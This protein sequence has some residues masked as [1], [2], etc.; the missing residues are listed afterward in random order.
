MQLYLVSSKL[1]SVYRWYVVLQCY[2]CNEALHHNGVRILLL[3]QINDSFQEVF[4]NIHSASAHDKS[5]KVLGHNVLPKPNFSGYT[6]TLG[7]HSLYKAL[8]VSVCRCS[9]TAAAI[10]TVS[11]M[12]GYCVVNPLG[13][14]NVFNHLATKRQLLLLKWTANQICLV[15]YF[16]RTLCPV[17]FNYSQTCLEIVQKL[18]VCWMSLWALIMIV[19]CPDPTHFVE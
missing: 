18:S 17:K 12:W 11:V 8:P 6:Y 3:L 7:R 14:L 10:Q 1:V 9:G 13:G 4:Y 16:D 19:S 2:L 5:N 15:G